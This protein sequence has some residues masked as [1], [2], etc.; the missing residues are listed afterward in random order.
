M[1]IGLLL[2]GLWAEGARAQ[3]ESHDVRLTLEANLVGWVKHASRFPDGG[4]ATFDLEH[5][6]TSVSF[7]GAGAL[8]AGF[9][10]TRYLIPG[11]LFGLQ[12]AKL[13]D[14][15]GLFASTM[16][17][18]ELRPS[19]EVAILPG[20]RIVPFA[21][22][23]LSLVR[24]LMKD[25]DKEDDFTEEMKSFGLGPAISVGIH[26]FIFEHASLDL[27]LTYRALFFGKTDASST[28]QPDDVEKKQQDHALLLNL[29]ASF[30]I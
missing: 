3:I 8:S 12:H 5:T 13:E 25:E 1:L 18:W 21:T 9:A 17:R 22:V 26:G 16:R 4:A 10:V 15:E 2:W 20:L 23:G 11:L 6:Q 30:W 19:L 29:G 7:L 24:Q 14:G 27:S 28:I